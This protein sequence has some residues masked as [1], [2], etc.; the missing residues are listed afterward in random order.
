MLV[1]YST[2]VFDV[3]T[4]VTIKGAF[5]SSVLLTLLL[6]LILLLPLEPFEKLFIFF[7]GGLVDKLNP[8]LLVESS[9]SS[10]KLAVLSDVKL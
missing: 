2:E 6:L 3:E 8:L 9:S 5:V 1:M 4:F 7:T 10:L